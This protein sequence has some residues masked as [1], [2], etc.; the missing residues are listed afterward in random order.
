MFQVQLK[1]ITSVV[2][3]WTAIFD[4]GWSHDI[5]VY[6]KIASQKKGIPRQPNLLNTYLTILDI[7]SY[8]LRHFYLFIFVQ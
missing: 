6:I 7:Y 8:N 2:N 4:F 5:A 3:L 1:N